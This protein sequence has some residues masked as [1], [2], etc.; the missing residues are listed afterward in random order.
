MFLWRMATTTLQLIFQCEI[1][2]GIILDFIMHI[3]F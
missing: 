3:I 1:A 2:I